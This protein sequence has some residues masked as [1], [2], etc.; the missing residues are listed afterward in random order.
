MQ[1]VVAQYADGH[2]QPTRILISKSD[3][4]VSIHEDEHDLNMCIFLADDSDKCRQCSRL[5]ID[6]QF[7]QFEISSL[8]KM[9]PNI[10]YATVRRIG[11]EMWLIQH[12]AVDR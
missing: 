9:P 11:H 8:D 5:M 1:Q 3:A 4:P 6:T 12:Q 10:D 2:T 7:K